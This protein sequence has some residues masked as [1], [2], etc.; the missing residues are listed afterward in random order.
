[1]VV[2]NIEIFLKPFCFEKLYSNPK[3]NEENYLFAHLIPIISNFFRQHKTL[4]S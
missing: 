4:T 1:M 2:T 3:E